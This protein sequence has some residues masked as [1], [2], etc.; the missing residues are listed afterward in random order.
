VDDEESLPPLTPAANEVGT[1][2]GNGILASREVT[3]A[4]FHDAFADRTPFVNALK[5]NSVRVAYAP[6][7]DLRFCPS[8]HPKAAAPPAQC[9][10]CE[11]GSVFIH[12]LIEVIAIQMAGR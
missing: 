2:Y 6:A 11:R 12:T 9:R 3:A 7:N 5:C 8:L 10:R 4:F 1:C